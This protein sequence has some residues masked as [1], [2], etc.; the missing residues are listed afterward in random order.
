MNTLLLDNPVEVLTVFRFL[1]NAPTVLNAPIRSI[2]VRF[3]LDPV[4]LEIWIFQIL[5]QGPHKRDRCL[6]E[7]M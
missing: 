3:V 6:R 7:R 5:L 4:L 2:L 1:Q